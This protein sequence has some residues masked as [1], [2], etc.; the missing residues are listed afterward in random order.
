MR[1]IH[2]GDWHIGKRVHGVHMTQE[3]RHLLKQF[4]EYVKQTKPDVII[5]SGDLYDR[6][7]PPTEAVELL[8]EVLSELV[9][10]LKIKVIA[11]A[12][13]HDSPDRLS[14]ATKLLQKN[15][16]YIRGRM[17]QEIEPIIVEDTYGEVY[18]YP[19]PYAE[20]S[21]IREIYKDETIRDHDQG[22]KRVLETINQT[23]ELHKRKVCIAH[24]YIT[25][26]D[27]LVTSESERPLSIGGT[28]SIEADYFKSFN[29]VA[30][31]HLHQAQKV[32]YPHIRYSGSLMK[33]SF[34]EVNH[35]K[36]ITVV[37]LDQEGKTTV[38]FVNFEP[39]RDMRRIQGKLNDLIQPSVYSMANTQDY[40]MATLTDQGALIDAMEKLRQVYPNILRLERVSDK[41]NSEAQQTSASDAFVKKNPVELFEEFYTNS[42]GEVFDKQKQ[43]Y[44]MNIF[45][46]VLKKERQE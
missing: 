18:F 43:E 25:G 39:R 20:P 22:M 12:G 37:E 31:G 41:K 4:I 45:A 46:D 14:F 32:K 27:E 42:S 23:W 30:L 35:S 29:Y 13:N 9:I 34:S 33:Y 3:Q 44:V 11:I 26:G 2:T 21:M 10:T 36:S 8:D 6:S 28:E 19:I 5:I 38:E 7:V 24:G 16:L 1:I 17:T 15:G 40:I